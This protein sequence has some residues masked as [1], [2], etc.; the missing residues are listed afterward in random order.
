MPYDMTKAPGD[1]IGR[2]RNTGRVYKG[3]KAQCSSIDNRLR[4]LKERYGIEPGSA[5][6][7]LGLSNLL[8]KDERFCGRPYK[9]VGRP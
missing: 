4:I 2:D 5:D 9:R 7:V 8:S 3:A 1:W 6:K